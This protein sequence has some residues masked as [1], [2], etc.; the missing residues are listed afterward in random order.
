MLRPYK[1]LERFLDNKGIILISKKVH[2][3]E[4][5]CNVA[6]ACDSYDVKEKENILGEATV[7]FS[8][9]PSL[10]TGISLN[11]LTTK[12]QTTKFSSSNFQ[13]VHVM[14]Y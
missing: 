5:P 4:T 12:K 6:V 10:S 7:S 9:F 8:V 11:S 14:S 13:K 1:I 2:V 3:F